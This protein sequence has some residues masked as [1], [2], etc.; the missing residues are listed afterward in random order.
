MK[1]AS[2]TTISFTS[3][4]LVRSEAGGIDPSCHEGNKDKD[5]PKRS[6]K[7]LVHGERDKPRLKRTVSNYRRNVLVAAANRRVT[8]KRRVSRSARDSSKDNRISFVRELEE[9]PVSKEQPCYVLAEV[10][11]F[12]RYPRD[13]FFSSRPRGRLLRRMFFRIN[14]RAHTVHSSVHPLE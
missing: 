4:K 6:V 1:P 3:G 13:N 9:L 12:E 5:R 10:K 7:A 14:L 11:C 2:K 8:K